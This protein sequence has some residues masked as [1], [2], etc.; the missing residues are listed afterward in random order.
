[1][2]GGRPRLDRVERGA[3]DRRTFIQ[4]GI[5]AGLGAVGLSAS[6]LATTKR[7]WAAE[8][9]ARAPYAPLGI[10]LYTL[11][12]LLSDDVPGTLEQVARIGYDE[13]EFAGLHGLSVGEMRA[14]LDGVG[15]RAASSH[16]GLDVIRQGWPRALD[17]AQTLG[18][19][20][21]VCPSLP[22]RERT[23]DGYRR[24]ADDFNRAGEAAQAE[25]L[26][27]AFHNHA[28]EFEPLERGGER[29][30]DIL[31]EQCDPEL[32]RMQLDVFWAVHAGED[33]IAWFRAHP[34]RFTSIHAKDRTA[35]GRMVAVGRGAIDFGEVL[36]EGTAAGVEHVF[37]EH[38]RP[39]DPLEVARTSH[40]TLSAL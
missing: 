19:S 21:I 36:A 24:I 13:V 31:I 29:G 9:P 32:V 11:R 2:S 22:G 17:E 30:Y 15:L 20:W 16:V 26:G 28:A 18:Q 8:L 7:G 4:H 38:D 39:E 12:S 3:V 40:R 34:G 25:G 35:D 27:F 37:V 23:P 10:Q 5:A 6:V 14:I 1:M 33:P